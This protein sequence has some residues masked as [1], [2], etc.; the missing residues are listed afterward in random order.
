MENHFTEVDIEKESLLK[1]INEFAQNK[2]IPDCENWEED[3]TFPRKIFEELGALGFMG[4]LVSEEHEGTEL[5]WTYVASILEELARHYAPVAAYLGVHNMVAHILNCYANNL[6]KSRWLSALAT[7]KKLGAF[8]L[9]EPNAGSDVASMKTNATKN[10]DRYILNGTKTFITAGGEADYY[11]VFARIEGSGISSFMVEKG[12]K[13]FEFGSK[14][15]KMGYYTSTT[16]ELYFNDCSLPADNLVGK[17]GE[18]LK[19]SLSAL[20]GGRLETA[21][22]ALGIAQAALEISIDYARERKQFG[23]AIS[24]FQAIQFMLAD[25]QIGI[26]AARLLINNAAALLDNK[27]KA[28]LEAS[29]AKCF[30]T[31]MAMQVTTDAVQI[32]G[33]YGYMK[34]YKVERLIREAKLGQIVEGTNQIQR[35][36]IA[37]ELLK[38]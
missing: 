6:Q 35:L 20:D 26:S 30:A 4:M 22:V 23:R 17:E 15:K 16:T 37:R 27:Q 25:I 29:I 28:N 19:H 18:G 31:D 12:A 3:G 33:G 14:E 10:G 24:D 36:V 32:L 8:A 11:I 21:S 38:K 7:G 34:D 13:G 1:T 5:P 9:T 2:I